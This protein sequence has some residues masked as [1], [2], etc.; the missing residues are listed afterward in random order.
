MGEVDPVFIQDVK[1]R[2]KL[3]AIQAEGIPLIDLSAL[4]GDAPP[5]DGAVAD[6]AAIEGLVVEIGEACRKWGLF[7]VVN[8]GVAAEK[9]ER[10]EREAREFFGQGPE[11]KKKVRTDE[12]RPFG[13]H[14]TEHSKNVRDWKEVFDFT[15]QEPTIVPSSLEDGEEGVTQWTNQW[16]EH[17]PGLREACEEYARELEKLANKLMR[18]I[19]QSLGLP[20]DRFDEF[21]KDQ[22]SLVRLNHYPSCPLP[23]LVLGVGCHKDSEALTILAQDDVGGLEVKRKSDGEWVQVKPVPNAFIINIGDIIQV[24]SNDRYESVEHTV[25]VNSEKE[26]FSIPFFFAPPHYTMVQPLKELTD[27]HNPPK[28]RP[29]N[30]GKCLVIRKASN[31]KKLDAENLQ[32]NHFKL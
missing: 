3:A 7:A 12:K 13:Y 11:E 25:V 20:T 10:I 2:P 32:I 14:E 8:H 4:T 18:L 6:S 28:Y 27:K 17:P 30:W 16:P 23:H 5:S 22:T 15:M 1:H 31:F 24:W 9:R 29:F 19:A 21:L 26:R